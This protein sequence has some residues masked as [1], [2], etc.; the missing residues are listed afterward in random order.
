LHAIILCD[1][2]TAL[3]GRTSVSVLL[4]TCFISRCVLLFIEMLGV[5]RGEGAVSSPNICSFFVLTHII[6]GHDIGDSMFPCSLFLE[7]AI[8]SD[9]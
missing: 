3:C 8:S 7:L 4:K 6:Q 5:D 1:F 9:E 2:V